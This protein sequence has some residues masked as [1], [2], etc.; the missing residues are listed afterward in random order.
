MC[1]SQFLDSFI[2]TQ[3]K[4]NSIAVVLTV[5][6]VWFRLGFHDWGEPQD[7]LSVLYQKVWRQRFQVMLSENAITAPMA[8]HLLTKTSTVLCSWHRNINYQNTFR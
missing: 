1:F 7:L 4:R 2:L 6:S 3:G 5:Q 8:P